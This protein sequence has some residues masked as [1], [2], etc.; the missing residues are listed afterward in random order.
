MSN[1]DF[2]RAGWPE[3]AEEARRA[4]HY[5]NGDPRSSLF[6]ARRSIELMVNWLYRADATLR[7]PYKNDL[8]ALLYEPSFKRLVG[9]GIHTK[10]DLIRKQGNSAVH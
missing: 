3:I 8:A 7:K 9:P 10:L 5:T 4:E 1:F 2:L 6:Y